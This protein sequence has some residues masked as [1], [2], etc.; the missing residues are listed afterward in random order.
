MKPTFKNTLIAMA[1]AALGLAGT[2]CGGDVE[3]EEAD[4]T[5]THEGGEAS[6]GATG[7]G[8]TGGEG[9]CGAS[10][11]DTDIEDTERETEADEGG[12]ASCG[13]GSCG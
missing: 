6:C 13:E 12:E 2:A 7:G 1:T 10:T 11:G 9:S 4:S 8:A 5:T 3:V